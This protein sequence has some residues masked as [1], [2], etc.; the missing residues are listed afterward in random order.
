MEYKDLTSLLRDFEKSSW[1]KPRV[2]LLSGQDMELGDLL[3]RKLKKNLEKGPGDYDLLVFSHEPQESL[4]LQ[5]E[6]ADVPLFSKYRFILVRQAEEVLKEAFA[7]SP[8]SKTFANNIEKMPDRTLL[9]FLY[10]GNVSKQILNALKKQTIF[11]HLQTKKLYADQ[12]ERALRSALQ[13]RKWQLNSEAFYFLLENIDPKAGSLEQLL[14]SLDSLPK[15]KKTISVEDLRSVLFPNQG[16]DPFALVDA[17]FGGNLPQALSQYKRFRP[18]E[19]NF[20]V[21]L[22]LLL[23]RMDEIRSARIAYG[24]NM[25]DRELLS[26]LGL[27][28]RH[29]FVQKKILARLHK[30]IPRFTEKV[31]L[32]IYDFLIRNAEKFSLPGP[33]SQ[34]NL[35]FSGS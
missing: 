8:R 25:K 30:E 14:D 35:L 4:R 2:L 24:Q 27:G 5:S 33:P 15:E 17:L 1:E 31:Q 29:P 7:S 19:D 23:R 28:G 10:A 6:L 16:W 11:L 13:A 20:F 3:V 22:K 18:G 26:F 21:L 12:L 34:T 9:V 32:N